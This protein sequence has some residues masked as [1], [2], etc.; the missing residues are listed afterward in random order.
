MVP[1][2][3]VRQG[4]RWPRQPPAR[5]PRPARVL[6][7]CAACLLPVIGQIGRN[8]AA[9]AH[10]A[11]RYGPSSCFREPVLPGL[12]PVLAPRRARPRPTGAD[13][14]EVCRR[15]RPGT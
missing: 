15:A 3:R 12:L 9:T 10:L 4:L 8:L 6:R 13:E 2:A 7:A 1:P 5:S 14:Q 11:E